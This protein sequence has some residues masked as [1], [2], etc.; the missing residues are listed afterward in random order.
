MKPSVLFRRSR[1]VFYSGYFQDVLRYQYTDGHVV[2][3]GD[4]FIGY[5]ETFAHWVEH[6]RLVE[7]EDEAA[8]VRSCEWLAMHW[9]FGD[10]Y[11]VP[12]FQNAVMDALIQSVLK[13]PMHLTDELRWFVSTQTDPPWIRPSQ[14]RRLFDIVFPVIDQ[15]REAQPLMASGHESQI[16]EGIALF[17]ASRTRLH[18][19]A[20]GYHLGPEILQ[21]GE[22]P[23]FGWDSCLFHVHPPGPQRVR[24]LGVTEGL[25]EAGNRIGIPVPDGEAMD[26][27]RL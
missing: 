13:F 17:N 27:R 24:C 2:S 4:E 15:I 8:E 10:K 12:M 21:P 11:E 20:G 7:E 3:L 5:V 9:L 6:R 16:A 14:L 1:L 19:E 22:K 25:D 26:F 23:L 18:R